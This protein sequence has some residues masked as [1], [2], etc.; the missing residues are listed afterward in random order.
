MT[1][2]IKRAIL[3]AAIAGLAVGAVVG[4]R[5]LREDLVSVGVGSKAPDFV[6]ST[7]GSTPKGKGLEDYA[8]QVVL[9]NLWATWCAPCRVEMPSIQNL[10][11]AYARRGL[12]VV[13][14][15]VDAGGTEQQIRSFTDSLGLTFEI[16]HD[17]SGGIQQR[18]RTTG[19]PETVLIGRD[20][21][22]RKRVRGAVHWDSPAN[23]ALVEQLL[24]RRATR[25]PRRS[26]RVAAP[27]SGRS[28]ARW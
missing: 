20:G 21:V 15:S 1:G 6:A 13:A 11:D 14:V 26:S 23:R 5:F 24:G 10:H 8:G 12:K 18:Y 9:L 4:V 3:V 7:L 22:I 19:V 16:L 28:C 27:A 25:R 2:T 17:S